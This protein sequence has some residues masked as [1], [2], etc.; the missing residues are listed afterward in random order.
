[1]TNAPWR[2]LADGLC[3]G[4]GSYQWSFTEHRGHLPHGPLNANL[5]LISQTQSDRC[6][7]VPFIIEGT[8]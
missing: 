7:N 5:L 3:G 1:M 2:R 6:S 8:Q 4:G